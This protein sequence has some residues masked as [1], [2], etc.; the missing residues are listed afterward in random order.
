MAKE[1]NNKT[2]EERI[3]A[4]EEEVKK[5]KKRGGILSGG[6]IRDRV[7]T[8]GHAE[9]YLEYFEK[10]QW[11]KMSSWWNDEFKDDKDG[12]KKK[13]VIKDYNELNV[14]PFSYD[15]SLGDQVFSIQNPK[16]GLIALKEEMPY[17]LKPGET[18]VVITAEKVAI[19]HAYSAT[20]WPR[21]NMVKRGVFQSMVK[22]DPTWHGHLAIA[23]SNLSPATV[24]LEYRKAFAT[25]LFY[26]LSEESDVDLW[27]LKDIQEKGI[28]VV[29]KIPEQFKDDIDRIDEHIFESEE[30]RGYCCVRDQSIVAW[31]IKR[32]NVE[33]L[34]DCL[35]DKRWHDTVD[36]LAKKWTN[37]LHPNGKR[38]IVMPAIGMESLWDIVKGLKD[39]GY[40]KEEDI[41]GMT[42]E[43]NDALISA[44]MKYGEPFDL[45]ANIPNLSYL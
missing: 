15:L 27:K 32:E 17:P 34:K 38:M 26:E 33:A 23:M 14:T 28:E 45:I 7:L 40:I 12:W 25:L 42:L 18:V 44:A 35:A 39:E 29:E 37:K 21:F 2:P 20:V 13:I 5:L 9:K 10:R 22:I 16:T 19:P 4:L 1:E 3:A 36:R 8:N 6:H 31:G 11:E 41:R 24:D 30:L 43:S